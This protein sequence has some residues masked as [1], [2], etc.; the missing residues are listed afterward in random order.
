MIRAE[1]ERLIGQAQAPYV[2]HV[3]P[4]LVESGD[5]RDRV[6]RVLVVDAPE[7]MQIAR[8]AAR[9]RLDPQE[10]RAIMRNQASRG[11]RLAVADDVIDNGGDFQALRE[12]VAALHERYLRL[13]KSAPG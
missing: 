11:E 6:D 1:S 3:V 7:E 12:Q 9:S 10:V 8:V 5:Y 2:V 13:A 4:L